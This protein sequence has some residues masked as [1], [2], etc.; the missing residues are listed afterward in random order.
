MSEF[1]EP[2]CGQEPGVT[3]RTATWSQEPVPAFWDLS[4]QEA[5][6]KI[7]RLRS[8]RAEPML[9]PLVVSL[10]LSLKGVGQRKTHENSSR[11]SAELSP[12]AGCG[13]GGGASVLDRPL[14]DSEGKAPSAWKWTRGV[15]IRARRPEPPGARCSAHTFTGSHWVNTYLHYLFFAQRN[16]RRKSVAG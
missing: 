8:S 5:S 2:G 11:R 14:A 3:S 16:K 10:N 6:I 13:G 12:L 4:T 15:C 9:L 1:C 7:P